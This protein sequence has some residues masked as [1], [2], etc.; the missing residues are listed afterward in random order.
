MRPAT[1]EP[2]VPPEPHAEHDVVRP[3]NSAPQPDDRIYLTRDGRRLLEERIQ[4]VSATVVELQ[5]VLDDPEQRADTVEGYR[6]ATQELARL[7]DLLERASPIDDLPDDPGVVELGDTVAVRLDD[8]AEETYIIVDASEASV[9]YRRISMQSPLAQALL[10]R[11]VGTEV[12]IQIPVGS[13]RCTILS[14]R[15]VD[16]RR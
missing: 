5:R 1:P 15:R 3:S 14:A 12:E 8:G 7:G 4:I 9:E 11:D 2:A 16:G 10:G 13:Y 6:R